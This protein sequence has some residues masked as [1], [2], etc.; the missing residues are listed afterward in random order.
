MRPQSTDTQQN[1]LRSS[2]LAAPTPPVTGVEPGGL[3]RFVAT[4]RANI[5]AHPFL[6]GLR[7][8]HL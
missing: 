5:G 4:H 8:G 2:L 6:K 1:D 3:R 7:V